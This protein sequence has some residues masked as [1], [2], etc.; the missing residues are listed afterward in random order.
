MPKTAGRAIA[1]AY[2]R[3]QRLTG[4]SV[5]ASGKGYSVTVREQRGPA[6]S[7]TSKL[8]ERIER[9]E[10][11]VRDVD[12]ALGF[13]RDIVGLEVTHADAERALVSAPQGTPLLSLASAGVT[14]PAAR[15]A[16]GLF[17][18]AIRYPDRRALGESLAR[19]VEARYAV[20]A[21]DHGVSE[22]LYVDDPD[23]N[24]VELYRDR[25]RDQWPPP[26][27]GELVAMGTA[28]VDLNG[29]LNDALS[30]GAVRRAAPAGTVVGHVHF[31]VADIDQTVEFYAATLGLDLMAKLGTQ[32]A[33]FASYGYHHHIGANVWNSRGQGPATRAHAGL[34]RLVLS[35]RREELDTLRHRLA[36]GGHRFDGTETEMVVMDPSGIELQ[37]VAES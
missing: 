35:T 15:R 9:V 18:T 29:L 3:A 19:L 24:G 20:G 7:P 37:F 25:P 16:T 4:L 27:P 11:R 14:A 6:P 2:S 8:I 1:G 26:R 32:A 33:F 12:R 30:H 28:P 23:G 22:A 13:Y 31:Q 5:Q 34:D 10:L 17:H 21:G 36:Q